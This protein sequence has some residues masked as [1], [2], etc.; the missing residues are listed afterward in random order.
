[1]KWL[2]LTAI[3]YSGNYDFSGGN[4]HIGTE[5]QYNDANKKIYV[6]SNG[7]K[8]IH[9]LVYVTHTSA[10]V[11]GGKSYAVHCWIELEHQGKRYHALVWNSCKWV[12]E[13]A[14]R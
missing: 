8:K 14:N 10:E 1:V 7:I 6:K 9:N 5:K 11:R 13:K 3:M 2:I 4:H 12:V